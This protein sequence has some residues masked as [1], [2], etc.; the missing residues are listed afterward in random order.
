M[1]HPPSIPLVLSLIG[2]SACASRAD[3]GHVVRYPEPGD[4]VVAHEVNFEVAAPRDAF[5]AAFLAAPLERFITGAKSL[6]GVHHTEP[7]TPAHYPAVGSVR[8][9]VLADGHTAHEEVLDCD[10]GRLRYFVTRYTTPQARPIEWGLGEFT[11]TPAGATTQVRWRYS[12]KLRSGTF[13][14]WL[15]GLGRALFRSRFVEPEYAPFM[16]A[17]VHEIQ[18]FAA[19]E[20]KGS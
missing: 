20:A 14:G 19:H 1:V 9:V 11:F 6:P 4:A 10:R 18:D 7:L 17:V 8:L 15:G 16:A 3:A 5:V 2:L 12:F 13:P